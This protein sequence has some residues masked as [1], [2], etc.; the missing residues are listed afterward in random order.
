MKANLNNS[1]RKFCY[2]GGQG[3]EYKMSG[4]VGFKNG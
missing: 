4:E 3:I 1:Y 2:K